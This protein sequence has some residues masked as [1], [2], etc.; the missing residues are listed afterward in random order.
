MFV[1]VRDST[2]GPPRVPKGTGNK[3][4][5]ALGLYISLILLNESSGVGGVISDQEINSGQD[6]CCFPRVQAMKRDRHKW[7]FL[8]FV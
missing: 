4:S 1:F 6:G 2:F 7:V 3:G 8:E 5:G